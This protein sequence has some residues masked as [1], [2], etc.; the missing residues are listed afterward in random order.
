MRTCMNSDTPLAGGVVGAAGFEPTTF[1]AQGRRATRLRYAPPH[2]LLGAG[3][4][5]R[6]PGRSKAQFPGGKMAHVRPNPRGRPARPRALDQRP[7][8]RAAAL[9]PSAADRLLPRRLL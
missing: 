5:T 6:A 4:S 9:L 3:L 8:R 2:G 7:G 1:C